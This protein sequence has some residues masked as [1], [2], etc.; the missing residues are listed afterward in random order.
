VAVEYGFVEVVE[1]LQQWPERLCELHEYWRTQAPG[2]ATEQVRL[3]C[4]TYH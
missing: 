3:A 4:E 1:D 2:D